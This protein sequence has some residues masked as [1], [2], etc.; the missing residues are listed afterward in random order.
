VGA[1]A[2]FKLAWKVLPLD[3]VQP[4]GQAYYSTDRN[5]GLLGG[6]WWPMTACRQ[7]QWAAFQRSCLLSVQVKSDGLGG[8]IECKRLVKC[9][10]NE[11]SVPMQSGGQVECNFA[12]SWVRIRVRHSQ[13]DDQVRGGAMLVTLLG[14]LATVASEFGARE[15]RERLELGDIETAVLRPTRFGFCD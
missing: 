8:Q 5:V 4:S 10:A 12:P 9:N 15:R 2:A 3:R 13:F 1:L 6:S 11:W 7:Q 14:Q